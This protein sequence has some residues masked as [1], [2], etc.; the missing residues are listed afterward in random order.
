[1]GEK[2]TC[3]VPLNRVEGDLEIRVS[4]NDHIV[5]DSWSSGTMFRGF[6]KIM[7]GRGALDGLVITPRICGICC[8]SH[9]SAA[10]TALDMIAGIDIPDNALRIR[11]IATMVEHI[12]SDVRHYS[13]M[14]A[15]DFIN[16][17]YQ[18]NSLFQEA[19]QRYEPFKGQVVIDTI[20]E[21]KR[22]LEIIA[23]FGGQWPHTSFMVPGG[24]ASIPSIN[25]ICLARQILSRFR[26][27]YEKRFLGCSIERWNAVKSV[28][29]F[30]NWL[31]E[32]ES[33]LNSEVG[34]YTRFSREAG[35]NKIGMGYGNFISFGAFGLPKDTEVRGVSNGLKFV[36]A[37]FVSVAGEKSFIQQMI[38]EDISH[39]WFQGPDEAQH[40]FQGS[41]IPYATGKESQKY[42][43]AK[44]PR[45]DGL[46]SETGPLAEAVI[47]RD[48]LFSEMIGK[49]GSSVFARELARLVRPALFLPIIDAWLSE[50]DLEGQKYYIPPKP[51]TQGEGF[52]LIEAARGAL[53]HWVKLNNGKITHYQIITPTAWNGS[54]RDSKG[55][56]GPWEEALIGTEVRD[57]DNPIEIGHVIRSFDSCMVCSVHAI[58]REK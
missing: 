41:T 55:V 26:K 51:I 28:S 42:S 24:I 18:K 47:R 29:D 15:P 37:G 58:R 25:D 12:Q 48:P 6:E 7:Q 1:M 11:N 21:T 20:K 3:V 35:L 39:S 32:D 52:G 16:P 50:L 13:L 23:I 33:H 36:P 46:P 17:S 27:W 8:I 49:D 31:A 43:W 57:I 44:A 38:A 34:F 30:E 56:R 53:G 40:P 5:D 10:A 22:V 19:F 9:L 54:P 45:Y 14:F 4:I 2:V